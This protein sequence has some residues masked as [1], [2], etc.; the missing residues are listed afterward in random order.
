MA[1]MRT[2][3]SRALRRQPVYGHID[4]L[5]DTYCDGHGWTIGPLDKHV[6][7]LSGS[8]FERVV[9]GDGAETLIVKHIA[10]EFDWLMRVL[11]DGAPGHAPRALIVWQEGYL[12]AMPTVIDTATVGMTYDKAQGHVR[13]VMRDVAR[14]LVSPGSSTVPLTQHRQFLDHMAEMH[15]AFWGFVDHHGL[16]TP[17][18]RYGFAHPSRTE[19]E[20]AAGHHE[21]IPEL[22]PHGW[23]AVRAK[24]PR[25]ADL[26]LSI[27]NDTGALEAAMADGPQTL[28]HG[29]WKFGN[30][31]SWPDGRT[32]LLDWGWPGQAGPCVDLGWYL[33]VN[34]DR[35]PES[36]ED[37]IEGYRSMLDGKGVATRGW[38]DRQLDLALLGAFIQMG[39]SKAGN[40]DELAWWTDRVL[41]TALSLQ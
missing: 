20:R 31:G 17:A 5:L 38:W 23:A 19:E 41:P 34:C 24:A 6:D 36:K 10:A 11:G 15:A 21:P 4:E 33:A 37:A 22:F 16:T 39:W 8:S 1:G 12:A 40:P 3:S 2:A 30:L 7:S 26:A 18:Q 32:V 35:L 14:S 28:V 29:D 9:V 13:Q 25:A 27:A